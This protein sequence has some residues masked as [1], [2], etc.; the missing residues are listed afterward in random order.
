[1]SSMLH[2]RSPREAPPHE[3]LLCWAEIFFLLLVDED[4]PLKWPTAG[5]PG[6]L[7]IQYTDIHILG[8]SL[9]I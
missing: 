1:V 8:A 9:G 6:Y 7:G 5:G 2:H 3:G 4:G